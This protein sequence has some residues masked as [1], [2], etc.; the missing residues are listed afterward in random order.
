MRTLA[1]LFRCTAF[2]AATALA[3]GAAPTRALQ[4]AADPPAQAAREAPRQAAGKP[5]LKPQQPGTTVEEAILASDI[6]ILA[7]LDK[8]FAEPASFRDATAGDIVAAVRKETELPIEVDRRAL[9]DAGGWE[10]IRVTCDPLTPRAALDA[11]LRSISPD[12]EQ[13]ALDVASG[14]VVMTDASGQTKLRATMRYPYSGLLGRLASVRMPS[15]GND[16]A[17]E[18]DAKEDANEGANDARGDS[19]VALLTR[20]LE[21]INPDAWKVNGG[22]LASVEFI[23]T[24]A[25]ITATPA[26]HHSIRH[27]IE[28]L[29]RE[30]PSVNLMWSVRVLALESDASDAAVREAIAS[31]AGLDAL[32]ASGRATILSAPRLLSQRTKTAEISIGSDASKL[33]IAIAPMHTTTE[34]VFVVSVNES[35]TSPQG[36]V[37]RSVIVRAT[38]GVR[39]AATMDGSGRRL[40]VEVAGLSESAQRLLDGPAKGPAKPVQP[41]A[42]A[43]DAKAK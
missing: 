29:V 23:G 27:A 41:A 18:E 32:V 10:F 14:I 2:V 3:L 42:A 9:G 28:D 5:V 24:I 40:L 11:V 20:Y 21:L 37:S 1:K 35:T 43:A 34:E 25:S 31:A 8:P 4:D 7:R 12:Y 22:D 16:Q 30:L 17:A 26:M 36:A 15:D 19:P 33:A 38:P 6:A 39:C 13:Y